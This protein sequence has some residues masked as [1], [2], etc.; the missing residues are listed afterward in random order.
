MTSL[1]LLLLAVLVLVTIHE[2]TAHPIR[3]A[4]WAKIGQYSDVEGRGIWKVFQREARDALS[5]YTPGASNQ[6]RVFLLMSVRTLVTDRRS[7]YRTTSGL[8]IIQTKR[9]SEN[10]HTRSWVVRIVRISGCRRLLGS[11]LSR[12]WFLFRLIYYPSKIIDTCI[13]IIICKTKSRSGSSSSSSSSKRKNETTM[14]RLN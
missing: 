11:Q 6:V 10:M 12:S 4:R 7:S 3:T 5:E 9:S 14:N 8:A 1:Y 13:T 2:T